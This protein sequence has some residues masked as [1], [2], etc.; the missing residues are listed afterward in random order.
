MRHYTLR[1]LR[2][3]NTKPFSGEQI[4]SMAAVIASESDTETRTRLTSHFWVVVN[5]T[6]RPFPHTDG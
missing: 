6:T 5:P 3:G 1:K 4:M 2:N